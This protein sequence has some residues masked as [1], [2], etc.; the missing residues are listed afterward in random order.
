MTLYVTKLPLES[1]G[2]RGDAGRIVSDVRRVTYWIAENGGGLCRE[3]I[4][5]ATGQGVEPEIG[6]SGDLSANLIAPEVKSLEVRYFDGSSWV[7]SWDAREP[8]D[9]GITPRGAPRAIEIRLGILPPGSK[10]GGELKHYR[11]VI[12]ISSANGLTQASTP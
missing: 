1:A 2:P 6:P 5:V 3:E 9:D 12:P 11:H 10:D 8:G 4:K 7:D